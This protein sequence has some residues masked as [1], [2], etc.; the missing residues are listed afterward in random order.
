MKLTL[1][2]FKCHSDFSIEIQETGITMLDGRSGAGKTTIMNAIIFA[3]YGDVKN[4]LTFGKKQC[5][6]ELISTRLEMKITR[7]YP[8]KLIIIYKEV[9]YTGETAQSIINNLLK[10]NDSQ[11]RLSSAPNQKKQLSILTLTPH[12]QLQFVKT[13]AESINDASKQ[14]KEKIKEHVKQLQ[15]SYS[16]TKG[17]F[18]LINTEFNTL[19]PIEFSDLN[20]SSCENTIEE[21]KNKQKLIFDEIDNIQSKIKTKKIELS[22]YGEEEKRVTRINRDKISIEEKIK[23]LETNFNNLPKIKTEKEF[24]ELSKKIQEKKKLFS[25]IKFLKEAEE[26]KTQFDR[27]SKLYQTQK[28]TFE[29]DLLP[30]N[31][32]SKF[33]CAI[34]EY[35]QKLSE[36]ERTKQIIESL[37]NKKNESEEKLIT[38]KNDLVDFINEPDDVRFSFLLKTKITSMNKEKETLLDEINNVFMINCPSCDCPIKINS[39]GIAERLDNLDF[40]DSQ[41]LESKIQEIEM[42]LTTL[43][44]YVDE[45]IELENHIYVE[46]PKLCE[47][48]SKKEI[49]QIKEKYE[50][51]SKAKIGLSSLTKDHINIL[52]ESYKDKKR[53]IKNDI[54]IINID[55]DN[56]SKL[57]KELESEVETIH[58]IKGDKI[59]LQ[60]EITS[61]KNKL[62]TYDNL[63]FSTIQTTIKNLTDEI[64]KYEKT[65][66]E[67]LRILKEVQNECEFFEK[68]IIKAREAKEFEK[69]KTKRDE[70]QKSLETL[71]K[72][73][74][75]ATGLEQSAIEAEFM[76]L[77]R[78][79]GNIN[80]HAKIYLDEMF[81]TSINVNLFV[82]RTTKAGKDKMKPSIGVQV[83]YKNVIYPSVDDLC[84]GELQRCN[85]AFLLGVNDMF[86]SKIIL[87]DECLNDNDHRT[88]MDIINHIKDYSKNKMVII[89]S[90]QVTMR[91]SVDK[92]IQ[93]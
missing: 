39:E 60:R 35:N 65:L 52:E 5:C 86:S 37:K 80:N 62:S 50:K 58:R 78:I 67:N 38:I 92:V 8:Y 77:E 41:D 59:K 19:S 3:F 71:E 16:E 70:L 90:H 82:N 10:M 34:D 83:E 28:I 72:R 18:Q 87:L 88:N 2:N 61:S 23:L 42:I 7:Y 11:F 76:A 33:K 43:E 66:D 20:F 73:L 74:N 25:D 4:P 31:E 12:E 29:N 47:L 14:K 75:G 69:T 13:I 55:T 21:L 57:I 15:Q 84:A 6:V 91:S 32:E 9:E 63:S 79:I 22:K 53:G 93:I 36:N 30:E 40:V 81:D 45:V 54:N 46:I 56:L 17:K 26:L 85:V 89:T 49:K 1:K 64:N 68:S 44:D 27:A 24:D 51:H 48:I